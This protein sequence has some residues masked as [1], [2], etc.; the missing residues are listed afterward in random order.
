MIEANRHKLIL[1]V[2]LPAQ[3]VLLVKQTSRPGSPLRLWYSTSVDLQKEK[4]QLQY[5]L[6]YNNH[7]SKPETGVKLDYNL[8]IVKKVPV[9]VTLTLYEFSQ[10][11]FNKSPQ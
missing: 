10:L 8:W 6:N 4:A 9:T 2:S 1:R 11:N 5:S 3:E 7:V